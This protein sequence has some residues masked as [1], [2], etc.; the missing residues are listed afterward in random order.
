MN[1]EECQKEAEFEVCESCCDHSDC[2]DHCCLICGKDM[3][4]EFAARAE[5][6]A[7]M[8]EDR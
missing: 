4:E 7:D 2:D 3:C 6:Y 5:Y 1:C 8:L